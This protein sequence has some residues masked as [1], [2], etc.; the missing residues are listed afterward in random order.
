MRLNK[1]SLGSEDYLSA[2]SIRQIA[3]YEVC[4]FRS[5][6]HSCNVI[7]TIPELCVI[8]LESNLVNM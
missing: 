7:R 2:S 6:L 3:N 4:W 8:H 1:I 5:S